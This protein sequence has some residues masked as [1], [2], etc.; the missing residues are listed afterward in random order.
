MNSCKELAVVSIKQTVGSMRLAGNNYSRF[1]DPV[2]WFKGFDPV[3]NL[4]EDA[5]EFVL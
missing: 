3:F 5:F 1:L 4:R 2:F